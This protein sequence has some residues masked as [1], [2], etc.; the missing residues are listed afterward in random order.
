MAIE[1]GPLGVRVNAVALGFID[2]ATTREAV[3]DSQLQQYAERTP[4]GRLGRLD[5]VIERG[6]VP[7]HPTLSSTARS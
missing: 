2:V 1:L 7:V 5:E 6:R 4:L 3:A